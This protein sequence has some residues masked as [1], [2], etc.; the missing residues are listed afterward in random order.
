[1]SFKIR[2]D[3]NNIIYSTIIISKL[4]SSTILESTP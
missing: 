4:L 3:I 1:M 2:K